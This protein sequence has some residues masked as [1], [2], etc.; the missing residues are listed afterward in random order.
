MSGTKWLTDSP[1]FGEATAAELRHIRSLGSSNTLV[2]ATENLGG[3]EA[4]L[5][6][7]CNQGVGMPVYDVVSGVQSRYASQSGLLKRLGVMRK[8]GLIV[9]GP[10][11]KKSQVCLYASEPLVEE[12]G[13]ILLQNHRY[14]SAIS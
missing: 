14:I 12:L 6:L 9:D 7:L 8:A 3:Y 10:G 1:I 13:P 11:R 5:M 2:M 4:L